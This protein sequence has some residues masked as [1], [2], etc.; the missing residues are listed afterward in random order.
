MVTNRASD[1]SECSFK[2]KI[3]GTEMECLDQSRSIPNGA[4]LAF[5]TTL[6][7]R[8][9]DVVLVRLPDSGSMVVREIAK[10]GDAWQLIA[11]NPSYP[12]IKLGDRAA[13]VARATEF[14]VCRSLI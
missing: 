2:V 14:T 3:L 9:G 13:V 6:D 12:S 5:D 8:N 7:V 11:R 4:I 1:Q 10:E